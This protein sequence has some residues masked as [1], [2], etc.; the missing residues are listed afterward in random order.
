LDSDLT[1]L[2]LRGVEELPE[3]P[4]IPLYALTGRLDGERIYQ[5]SYAMIGPETMEVQLWIAPDTFELY[6]VVISEP[7][8]D[9]ADPTIWQLDFWDFNVPVEITPP[10]VG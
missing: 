2:V 1:N 8:A 7:S 9:P 6:R 3:L 4:G 5:M 10:L